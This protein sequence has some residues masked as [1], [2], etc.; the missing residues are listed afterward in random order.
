MRKYAA[1]NLV[2]SFSILLLPGFAHADFGEDLVWFLIS[3]LLYPLFFI[4]N[5]FAAKKGARLAWAL[6]TLLLYPL[7]SYCTMQ[8]LSTVLSSVNYYESVVIGFCINT[9]LW[10]GLFIYL[11]LNRGS[12]IWML[13]FAL[14]LFIGFAIAA[15]NEYRFFSSAFSSSVSSI[16]LSQLSAF[17]GFTVTTV[18]SLWWI[19][20]LFK[21]SGSEKIRLIE[22]GSITTEAMQIVA[23]VVAIKSTTSGLCSTFLISLLNVASNRFYGFYA[24]QIMGY[25]IA[26]VALTLLFN[27]RKEDVDSWVT[28]VALYGSVLYAGLSAISFL[29]TLF[30]SSQEIH[31]WFYVI[32]TLNYLLIVATAYGIT[33][34][35]MDKPSTVADQ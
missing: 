31:P 12:S 16:P 33:Y 23:F 18:A 27:A 28:N 22:A 21:V 20:R 29:S 10:A 15:V 30:N 14:F 17:L 19:A 32:P 3:G 6:A 26:C 4:A 2:I 1:A 25:L 7:T 13:F 9:L 11:V 5:T 8:L 24:S 35:R 34:L